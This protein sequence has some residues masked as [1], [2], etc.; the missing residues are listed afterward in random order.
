MPKN[1]NSFILTDNLIDIMKKNLKKSEEINKEI[2]FNL[3][4]VDGNNDLKDE[5]Y[6]IGTED[7]IYFSV[8]CDIG[9]K[10]GEFHTHP[11]GFSQ[12]SLNDLHNAC[13]EGIECIGGAKDKKIVCYVRKLKDVNKNAIYNAFVNKKMSLEKQIEFIQKYF[14]TIN[15]I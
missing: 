11:K 9:K 15:I 13:S 8:K 4:Q 7:S 3:C 10:V 5:N 2:G 12:P 14:D 6:H 1:I